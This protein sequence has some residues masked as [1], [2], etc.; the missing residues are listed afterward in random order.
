VQRIAITG[1]SGYY[2]SRLVRY[3]RNV[4]PG[5]EILGL[6]RTPP[7]GLG[8]Q[9]FARIDVRS[10]ELHDTLR[11]FQPDTVIHLAFVLNPIHD[12]ARMH[13]INI[14]GSNNVF[15]AV[16]ALRPHRFLMASSA[17]VFGAW[18]DNPVPIDDSG[19]VRGRP[20][21]EY[22]RDKTELEHMITGFA[23]SHPDIAVSW[24]R[25]AIICGPEMSNYLMR[26]LMWSP[27]VVLPDG[28][29]TP[30]QFVHEND[31]A[32]AT[33]EI[34]KCGGEGPFN[35]GPADWM[36]LSDI[37]RE[38]RRPALNIPLWMMRIHAS[39]W[40]SLRLP[41][42]NFPPAAHHYLRHPWVVAPT[43][44]RDELGFRFQY[45]SREAFRELLGMNEQ[46]GADNSMTV[47]EPLQRRGR[48]AA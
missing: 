29:D 18:P 3:I 6:G 19:P 24:V 41:I 7:N 27:F 35:I 33:W 46:S 15:E 23:N 11:A 43:R 13:D 28:F 12:E 38:R 21:L 34:L 2:G 47:S 10:P 40:W 39:I 17:T 4:D 30:I 42:F 16:H 8:P 48:R 9:K 36:N 44:L 1:S 32:A 31:V 14:N 26:M 22:S 25:P 45:S 20:E 37:A 5:V